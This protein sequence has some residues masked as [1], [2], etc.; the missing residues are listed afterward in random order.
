MENINLFTTKETQ[1]T[2][3]GN[4]DNCGLS[5]QNLHAG[6]VTSVNVAGQ[7]YNRSSYDFVTLDSSIPNLP[8]NAL[9]LGMGASWD[10]IFSLALV[11]SL[12]P[13][14]SA[15]PSYIPE[16]GWVAY[17]LQQA[18]LFPSTSS[19][20]PNPG[21]V[22]D[23][24]T[25]QLGFNGQMTPT[26]L[27]RLTGGPNQQ[28]TV[29]EVDAN[30]L[31]VL[32]ASG[33]FVTEQ[34]SWASPQA[35]QALYMAS[36]G[37]PN[38]SNPGMG[39]QIGG[40]GLLQVNAGS[41]FLGNSYGILS[42]GVDAQYAYL[43]SLTP[44]GASVNVTAAG[45]LNMLTSTIAALGG[46]NVN[47]TSI[48]G[49]MDLGSQSLF[50]S[51]F[52]SPGFG[53]FTSGQGNV[54]VTAEGDINVD[55]SRIAT[56]DGGNISVESLQGN[57]NAGTGGTE[58]ISLFLSYVDPLTGKANSY[59]EAVTGSGIMATTLVDP[60]QVP[61]S[62]VLPGNISV[63]TPRGSIYASQGGILQQALNGSVAGGP[64]ITLAAGTSA[65][66]SSP[67]YLGNIDLG[68]SGVIGGTVN[69]QANGNVS[70]L[71]IARQS[72]T[73][74]AAQSFTGTVLAGGSATLSAGGSVSGTVIAVT[75]ASVSGGQ[76]VTATVLSQSA[77]VGGAAASSTLGTT[78]TATTASTAAAATATTETRDQLAQESSSNPDDD[79]KKK[80]A[81][82][83]LTRRVGRVTVILPK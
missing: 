77:S 2:V 47:V 44:L 53:I 41:I 63:L 74:N 60:S 56:Y 36:Q 73:I 68:N 40:P 54:T 9:P 58:F 17:I 19:S 66:A 35:L 5:G 16:S 13:L 24:A 75:S 45:D 38:P 31:P 1:I 29:L 81:K 59:Q 12:I 50:G 8:A 71:V 80:K 67:G 30:G 34:V 57:V 52:R 37:A 18:A 11:P 14:P 79:A 6:D 55:G 72:T 42:R 10:A 32:D 48:N 46:G 78:A 49:S 33:H 3:G 27:Q 26:V 76:G 28:L 51:A 62:P 23:P 39:I 43:A 70:G 61:G 15:I 22:Y 4:M 83:A 82:P 64:T 69:V 25:R 20:I 65:S 21:F 7:I